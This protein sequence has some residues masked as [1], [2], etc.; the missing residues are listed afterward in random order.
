MHKRL[1]IFKY[2]IHILMNRVNENYISSYVF[3]ILKCRFSQDKNALSNLSV[4]YVKVNLAIN[5]TIN[6]VCFVA[7][8]VCI[9]T[10]HI[11]NYSIKFLYLGCGNVL[12]VTF[13]YKNYYEVLLSTN[14]FLLRKWNYKESILQK[15]SKYYLNPK[16]QLAF[17]YENTSC[18]KYAT[19]IA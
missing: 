6:Y 8:Y 18:T 9:K 14:F 7:F 2:F 1:T 19:K 5:S 15:G 13:L 17:E 11:L 3:L 16:I 12:H 4:Y 10:R